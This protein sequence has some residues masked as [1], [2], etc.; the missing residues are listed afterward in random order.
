M[1]SVIRAPS[2]V[3]PNAFYR[4]GAATTQLFNAEGGNAFTV[5]ANVMLMDMGKTVYNG[6]NILR[7][8]QVVDNEAIAYIY[9]A[10]AA[11]GVSQVIAAL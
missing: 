6:V 11:G 1:S 4:V 8:V 10:K 5:N 9:L 2:Q 3:R 7:K